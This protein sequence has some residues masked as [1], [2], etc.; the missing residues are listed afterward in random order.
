MPPATRAPR[1]APGRVLDPLHRHALP[2]G[3][4]CGDGLLRQLGRVAAR[5]LG[6]PVVLPQAL[7]D[8]RPDRPGWCCTSLSRHGLGMVKRMTPLLLVAARSSSAI[9]VMVPGVGVTMNGATRWLGAGPLQFQPS[10][11]LKLVADPLRGPAAG[12]R[13][14]KSVQTLQGAGASRCCWWSG[15]ACALLLKQ[16]D[17]GTAMVICFAIGALLIAAGTPIRYL[18]AH[19]RRRCW[20]WLP[21]LAIAEPYRCERLTA[22]LDP[23]SDAGDTGFQAVQALTAI[24]SGGMFG[25]GPRRVGAE[26]LLPARGPHG[27]DP[28]DHRRGARARGDASAWSASTR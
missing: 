7:R 3:G 18:G 22:F 10:E 19:R 12:R 23:F 20:R 15:A 4:R 17:M 6:R 9:A 13:G 1:E 5:G 28:G 21:W 27:H 2:A 24:G 25:V 16:P 8:L 11:L 14:P 26:D